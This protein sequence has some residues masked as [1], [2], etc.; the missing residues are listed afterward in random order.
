MSKIKEKNKPRRWWQDEL[1]D[2]DQEESLLQQSDRYLSRSTL[3]EEKRYGYGSDAMKSKLNDAALSVARLMNSVRN[4]TN[5]TE[6]ELKIQWA[7][8]HTVTFNE[9]GDGNIVLSPDLVKDSDPATLDGI[10]GAALLGAT[11]K[12]TMSQVAHKSALVNR[13]NPA[14]KLDVDV[15]QALEEGKAREALLSEWPGGTP[16]LSRH[17]KLAGLTQLEQVQDFVSRAEDK[18]AAAVTAL[19]W[20]MVHPMKP[21]T[22]EPRLEALVEEVASELGEADKTARFTAA[23]QAVAKIRKWVE[24]T[25]PPPPPPQPEP[26]PEP[27]PEEKPEEEKP[28]PEKEEDPKPEE[29]KDEEDHSESD[30][31]KSERESS[32]PE[33]KDPD[34][35]EG[36]PEEKPDDKGEGDPEKSEDKPSEGDK[37]ESE[38]KGDSEE[39]GDD[40]GGDGKGDKPDSEEKS[41]EEGEGEN[42]DEE[43]KGGDS[44]DESD[45]GDKKENGDGK[46]EDSK[47]GEGE[48]SGESEEPAEPATPPP[49]AQPKITDGKQFGEY[50]PSSA[51]SSDVPEPM[52]ITINPDDLDKPIV[53]PRCSVVPVDLMPVQ[54]SN[55]HT[56]AYG[57]IAKRMQPMIKS[58]IQSLHFRKLAPDYP[59]H[60]LRSGD[61]DDG[62]LDKLA[63]R[64]QHPHIFE[65]KEIVSM[66][67]VAIAIL[68]DESGSMAANVKGGPS[69]YETA[70]DI[71]IALVEAL[72]K[73]QGIKLCVYGHT[74]DSQRFGRAT[75]FEYVSP[76]LPQPFALSQITSRRNNADGYAMECVIR[77]LHR[78]YHHAQQKIMFVLSDGQP[79]S[80][81]YGG[82]LAMIHMG[83]V[84]RWGLSKFGIRTYGIGIDG[85]P[86][87]E[88][89]IKMYGEGHFVCL[90]N[91]IDSARVISTFLAKVTAKV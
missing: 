46:P 25:P 90:P 34:K 58:V 51:S 69:R 23:E 65:R 50:V 41:D 28:E 63:L 64:E 43:G 53:P 81:S 79:S 31:D 33:D 54:A 52:S 39:K 32:Y 17:E 27:E 89:G 37:E 88:D 72:R 36:E 21:L 48:G 61:L 87:Q 29:K 44:K 71:C 8:S 74:C 26:E 14:K 45:G 30:E 49:T 1:E 57:E 83:N 67:D 62:S 2:D 24:D 86:S 80:S 56:Q 35:G 76:N 6:R 13:H 82:N 4:S 40:S 18:V 38:D 7:A 78:H 91:V 59:L 16:Y 75:V 68:V 84:C 12:T 9:P 47:E 15:W 85:L 20:T 70:R 19:N 22:M 73:L 66:P 42:K 11:L 3:S 60:G 5:G 10:G 77:Q 55:H